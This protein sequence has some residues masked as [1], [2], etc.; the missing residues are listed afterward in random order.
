MKNTFDELLRRAIRNNN[1][2][3]NQAR[4]LPVVPR[5]IIPF[6][7]VNPVTLEPLKRVF[8]Y[9]VINK[10]TKR[11]NYYNKNTLLKLIGRNMSNYNLLIADPK[12]RLFRNPVTR[13]NV[14]PRNIQ[15]VRAK[16]AES[17]LKKHLKRR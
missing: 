5:R 4:A 17:V 9:E 11:K 14:K 6:A 10:T 15:R 13:G 7:Y 8:V 12:K 3:K 2:R 16:K 1:K